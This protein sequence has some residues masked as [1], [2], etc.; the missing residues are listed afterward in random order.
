V[1]YCA[2]VFVCLLFK[3][4]I[5]YH[6]LMR[7]EVMLTGPSKFK[8]LLNHY[9][10]G[11]IWQYF[12]IKWFKDGLVCEPDMLHALTVYK[13]YITQILHFNCIIKTDHS[14]AV[15]EKPWTVCHEWISN[16]VSNLDLWGIIYRNQCFAVIW[17]FNLSVTS[18]YSYNFVQVT[19]L[20]TPLE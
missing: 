18:A 10:Q 1:P 20:I 15:L 7:T 19:E 3:S 2:V 9:T 4:L 12:E 11:E 16:Y 6:I 8:A 14:P 5:I 17:L 13:K